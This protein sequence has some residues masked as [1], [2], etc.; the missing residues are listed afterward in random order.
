MTS[1]QKQAQIL[2]KYA[3][4]SAEALN[5]LR[6][7]S[8][9]TATESAVAEKAFQT[10]KEKVFKRLTAKGVSPDIANGYIK[11]YGSSPTLRKQGALALSPLMKDYVVPG[12]LIAPI[13]GTAITAAVS[14]DSTDFKKNIGKGLLTGAAADVLTSVGMGL[15]AQRKTL[16]K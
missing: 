1:F 14:K 11:T 5:V 13:A 15:Y 12:L 7:K 2:S 6:A 3:A 9:S 10:T 8:I 16:L 4:I